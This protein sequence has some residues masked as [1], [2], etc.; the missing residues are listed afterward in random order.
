[1]K[2]AIVKAWYADPKSKYGGSRES[3]EIGAEARALVVGCEQMF[4]HEYGE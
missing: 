3:L 4:M 1:M 2:F